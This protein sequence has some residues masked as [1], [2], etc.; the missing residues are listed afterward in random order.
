MNDIINTKTELE[1]YKSL[2][3]EV[4]KAQNEINCAEGDL[5][6]A[7]SRL[8]FL[9]AVLNQLINRKGQTDETKSTSRETATD[10]DLD[11]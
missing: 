4:A 9:V 6:K 5:K 11:R 3:A 7:R 1:L 8:S 2:L 10:Q